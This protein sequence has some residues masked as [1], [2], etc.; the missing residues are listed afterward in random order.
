[1]RSFHGINLF[2]TPNIDVN[3]IEVD[4]RDEEEG[5]NALIIACSK[6]YGEIVSQL[7]HLDAV[8][9]TVNNTDGA[10]CTALV[11]SVFHRQKKIVFQLLEYNR[12]YRMTGDGCGDGRLD[13]AHVRS[14]HETE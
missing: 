1:M 12:I 2:N 14:L 8:K 11:N 3:Q 4:H 10:G 13:R 9:D 6:G 5:Y 7:L